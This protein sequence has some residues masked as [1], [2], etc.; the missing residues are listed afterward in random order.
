MDKKDI[1]SEISVDIKDELY[2]LWEGGVSFNS[3]EKDEE[4]QIPVKIVHKG[5]SKDGCNLFDWTSD[6]ENS[7]YYLILNDKGIFSS[8]QATQASS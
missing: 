3:K 6:G 2:P 5:D 8:S 4:I 1:K 7:K